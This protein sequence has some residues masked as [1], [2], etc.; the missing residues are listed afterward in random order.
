MGVLGLW[1]GLASIGALIGAMLSPNW[2]LVKEPITLEESNHMNYAA[3]MPSE[4]YPDD[5]LETALGPVVTSVS[6]QLGLW[7][8]CPNI[9]TSGLHLSKWI[10]I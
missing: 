1:A 5:P 7:N 10:T 8:V 3:K 9:N 6:F 4:Y 2:A